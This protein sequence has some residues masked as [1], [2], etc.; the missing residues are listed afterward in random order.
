MMVCIYVD[1]V[2]IPLYRFLLHL[3]DSSLFSI[4]SLVVVY[5]VDL[6]EKPAPGLID[7]LKVFLCLFDS[8]P[9]FF[10]INLAS[11]LSILLIFSKH[12]LLDFLIF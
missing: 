10:F 1:T 9:S 4:I 3:F 12:Q 8:S 2:V 6:L 5:F 11:D 7:F